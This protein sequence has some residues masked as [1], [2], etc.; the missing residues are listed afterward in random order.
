MSLSG[1]V[2]SV[3][4]WGRQAK[5]PRCCRRPGARHMLRRNKS[6]PSGR[7][8]SRDRQRCAGL[9]RRDSRRC[10][11]CRKR[12]G[13][14]DGIRDKREVGDASGDLFTVG[15]DPLAVVGGSGLCEAESNGDM[16]ADLFSRHTALGER[17]GEVGDIVNVGVREDARSLSLMSSSE[18]ITNLTKSTRKTEALSFTVPHVWTVNTSIRF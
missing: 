7:S 6:W 15:I 16:R 14:S 12:T 11:R 17:A 13:V 18:T 2:G 9:W 10:S 5:Q 8:S 4:R 3:S 1:R